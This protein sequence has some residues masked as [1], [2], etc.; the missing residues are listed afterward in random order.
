MLPCTESMRFR[1]LGIQF[2]SCHNIHGI[3]LLLWND[4]KCIR[5]RARLSGVEPLSLSENCASISPKSSGRDSLYTV[6]R[7][8]W[9]RPK[10]GRQESL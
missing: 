7:N 8:E 10:T 6:L 4:L 2:L 5:F 3:L 1:P 9:R